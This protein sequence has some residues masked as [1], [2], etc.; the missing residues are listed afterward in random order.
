MPRIY[1]NPR[2]HKNDPVLGPAY[3]KFCHQ[4]ANAKARGIEWLMSF[5]EWWAWWQVDGRWA[6]RGNKPDDF[7]MAR[8]GDAG[9]YSLGNVFLATF[10]ENCR[11][12]H[13]NGRVHGRKP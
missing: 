10:R 12:M 1:D 2:L 5:D 9:P 3:V 6:R 11:D 13:V 4:K 8:K 7:C